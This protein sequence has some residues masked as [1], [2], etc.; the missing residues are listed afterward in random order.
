MSAYDAVAYKRNYVDKVIVRVDLVSPISSIVA[1]L[2]L[3]LSH[4]AL[5]N[6]PI[7]EPRQAVSQEL[8]ISPAQEI[9]SKKTSFTEW[10]FHGRAREKSLVIVPGALFVIHNAYDNYEKV[11]EEFMSILRIFFSTFPETQPSRLGLRYINKIQFPEGDPLDWSDYIN[12]SML[13]LLQFPKDKKQLSRMF[14]NLEFAFEDFN[15]RYQF[16]LN[17]PDYPAKIRQRIFLLD[18]DA[19]HQGPIEQNEIEASL[20]KYHDGIQDMFEMSITTGLRA[21]MNE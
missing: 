21:M 18:L 17:N 1:A 13:A 11:R 5:S 8:Q 2:P 7:A 3:T 12:S 9:S 10:H 14:H 19:Y 15:L 4:A 20:N 6:F 16:G